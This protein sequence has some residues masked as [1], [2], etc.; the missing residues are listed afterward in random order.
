MSLAMTK[1]EREAF[2]ADLHVAVVSIPDPGGAPVTVPIWYRYE[3]GGS[4]EFITD[5]DSRK[6]KLLA[7]GK[8]LALCA[9]SEQPPYKYVTVEGVVAAIGPVDVERDARPIAR[10]YLGREQGDAYVQVMGPQ[11]GGS[12]LVRVRPERWRTVDYAKEP[13]G[14]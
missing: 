12:V 9:Q 2:L 3:P 6:G 1:D 8:P 7:V 13:L 10:R 5:R 14:L 4:I 11:M